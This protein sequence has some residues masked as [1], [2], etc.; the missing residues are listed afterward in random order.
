MVPDFLSVP[1]FRPFTFLIF[2][3]YRLCS[4]RRSSF[5]SITPAAVRKFL[6]TLVKPVIYSIPSH[7]ASSACS[8]PRVG[9]W[10]PLFS[11]KQLPRLPHLPA[12]PFSPQRSGHPPIFSSGSC[13]SSVRV[14]DMLQGRGNSAARTKT[15]GSSF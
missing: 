5:L 14:P 11:G 6:L 10:L 12:L 2:L 9:S 8:S 3:L 4:F 1:C 13:L 15:S 7:A